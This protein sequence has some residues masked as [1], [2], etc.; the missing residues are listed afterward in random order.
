MDVLLKV[1]SILMLLSWLGY[2]IYLIIKQIR[3]ENK[4]WRNK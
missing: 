2:N 1:A 4:N 3:Y